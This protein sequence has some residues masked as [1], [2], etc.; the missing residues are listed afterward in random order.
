[1]STAEAISAAPQ[2]PPSPIEQAL[3]L[4][5]RG[6]LTD[7]EQVLRGILSREPGQRDAQHLLGLVCHQQGRHVE[8][9]QLVGAAL[10]GASRSP[11]LLNNY[12]LILTALTRHQ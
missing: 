11:E 7:A 6:Q 2:R 10:A 4:R 5:Q 3:A 12:G 9:L 1:V 8:A